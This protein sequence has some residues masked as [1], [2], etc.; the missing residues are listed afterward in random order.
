MAVYYFDTSVLV[1]LYI[2][3]P[4]S[5]WVDQT[6]NVA[7]Q[8]GMRKNLIVVSKLGLPEAAAAFSRRLQLK[9]ITAIQHK[10]LLKALLK[11]FK[12][13]FRTLSVS[14]P[15]LF[16]AVCLTQ[17]FSLR[18]YDAVHLATAHRFNQTLLD[19]QAEP[20]V[21]VSSDF[22]LSDAAIAL[23]MKVLDPGASQD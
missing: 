18:A 16:S 9:D 13:K 22:A 15:I 20:L 5:T 17:N 3:E 12:S 8:S 7:N 10:T 2:N 21:F 6:V 1:K 19:D 4:G 23:K 11:D 14:D